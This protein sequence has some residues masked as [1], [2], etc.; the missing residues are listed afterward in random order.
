MRYDAGATPRH[1]HN[2]PH[3]MNPCANV[4]IR[5][6][7]V[8]AR[9][10]IRV[11][12]PRPGG[13]STLL[14]MEKPAANHVPRYTATYSRPLSLYVSKCTLEARALGSRGSSLPAR[15]CQPE[16]RYR[17]STKRLT[18]RLPRVVEECLPDAWTLRELIDIR[19]EY[20]WI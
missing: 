14:A 13:W 5:A 3:V 12:W 18:K 10:S 8:Q 9:V 17:I 7:C 4:T 1:G 15:G 2:L 19:E 16:P 11:V 20:L 6:V